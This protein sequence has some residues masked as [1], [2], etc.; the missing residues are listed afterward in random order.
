MIQLIFFFRISNQQVL[1]LYSER[2]LNSN[3]KI[4]DELIN[5]L[6]EIKKL[7]ASL[8][9]IIQEEY[10]RVS[11]CLKDNFRSPLERSKNLIGH[12][13]D[14]YLNMLPQS[15]NYYLEIDKKE[16]FKKFETVANSASTHLTDSQ[17]M[18][19]QDEF[20]TDIYR[21]PI[22][23]MGKF[24]FHRKSRIF[25]DPSSTGTVNFEIVFPFQDTDAKEKKDCVSLDSLPRFFREAS[26]IVTPSPSLPPTIFSYQKH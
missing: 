15:K 24:V 7:G 23:Q 20:L 9:S 22:V 11:E 26:G 17:T 18:A 3:R 13:H 16:M 19:F 14:L 2:L 6:T 4:S 12:L 8:N 25:F 10:S 21:K 5:M 1:R